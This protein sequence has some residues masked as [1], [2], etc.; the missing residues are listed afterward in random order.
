MSLLH[1]LIPNNLTQKVLPTDRSEG[2][3]RSVR[4]EGLTNVFGT[5]KWKSG[6]EAAAVEESP[7]SYLASIVAHDV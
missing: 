4:L 5:E 3:C 7:H 1:V 2:A 6:R